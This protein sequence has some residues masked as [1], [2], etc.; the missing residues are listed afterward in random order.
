LIILDI[1]RD[2]NPLTVA[3]SSIDLRVFG[4]MPGNSALLLPDTPTFTI[5]AVTNGYVQNSNKRRE[6]LVGKG[7]F[8]AF[9]VANDEEH[10]TS[11]KQLRYS[12]EYALLKKE[13]HHLPLHRYDIPTTNGSFEGRYWSAVNT[14][15]LNE[16]EEVL[17]IIHSADD[18][19]AQI[20]AAQKEAALKGIEKTFALFMHAPFVVGL[21]K[22]ENHVLDLA[23]EATFKLWG[24]GPEIVGKPLLEAVPEIQ[25]QGILELFEEVKR[26]GKPYFSKATPVVS[27][28]NGKEETHYF[29]LIY[30]PYYEDDPEKPIGV[31]TISH[32]VT[33]QVIARKQIEE[34][35]ALLRIG[36]AKRT[37][38]LKEQKTF[39]SSI[40][41]ASLS[42]IYAL[43]AIRSSNGAVDD[44]QY[45]FANKQTAAFL[46][47]PVEKIIGASMLEL[48]PE[49]KSNGFFD[50]FCTLLLSQETYR[51]ETHFVA[52]GMDHW[53]DFVIV[54]IDKDTLVVSIADITVRKQSTIE[55][56]EQRNLL[57]NILRNS[58]N[59]ISVSKVFRDKSGKVVDALTILANNAAVT[60][61]GLPKEIYLS[62]KATEIEPAVMNSP[63]YHACIKTLETGE[64]FVMQY[65]MQSTNRWLELTVSRLD[66]D[67]LIQIFTDVTAIKKAQLQLEQ[68]VEELKR[69]NQ[70]LEQFAYAASHDL[71]E[72]MRKVQI[73]SNRL[74][75][76][77]A[78][79]LEQE[80]K[81]YFSRILYAT[82]RMNTLIDDLLMYS[83]VSTGAVLDEMVDLNEKVCLV[84]EDLEVEI[85]EKNASITVDPL[86]TIKGHRRQ[87]QQLFQN[88]IGNAIKYAKLGIQ[89]QVHISSRVVTADDQSLP[90][91]LI[92]GDKQY[93]LIE[94]KDNGIGFGA[95]DAERIFQVFTR[96]HGN[97]EY[98][99]TGVGL[100]IVRK[101]VENHNGYIW[102]EGGS[103]GGATFK[104]LLPTTS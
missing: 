41:D 10:E 94:V 27:L 3:S 88:L 34:S 63:Y 85:S 86:P 68:S 81:H 65:E 93:Y 101:V 31:F 46:H 87:L 99:G 75:D 28:A 37:A 25:G 90:T 98:R 104:V 97:N 53:F 77:L 8:E 102:A 36:V 84:L 32:E 20:K 48:L 38:E 17:Y 64:P 83:H 95:E 61:I 100:S 43:K 103:G 35:E 44:F 18:V 74:K 2:M 1:S 51:D 52:Q 15:V 66:N 21:V 55:L 23:N 39:I 6:E 62:K 56:E 9:P 16:N 19:T 49:N 12:L 89:P 54:P 22:G 14:P 42:G 29:D 45:L 5:A 72:P 58:S 60:F 78:G 91:N 7:L 33:E 80:D 24:K 67:H 76:R 92:N 73:F 40:L 50:L 57:D 26:T 11:E 82:D 71:K 59:G 47:L 30:Q 69:S 13:S 4:A 79:K 96:L 70:N